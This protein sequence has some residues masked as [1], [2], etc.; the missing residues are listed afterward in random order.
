MVSASYFIDSSMTT[1]GSKTTITATVRLPGG[2]LYNSGDILKITLPTDTTSAWDTSSTAV[3]ACVRYF[4]TDLMISSLRV[5]LPF[6][7]AL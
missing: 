3:C 6:L 4:V 7:V 5:E 1:V 2:I